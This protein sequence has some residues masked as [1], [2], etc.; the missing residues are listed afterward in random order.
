MTNL[1][2]FGSFEGIPL[3]LLKAYWEVVRPYDGWKCP[4]MT[5][6]PAEGFLEFST[7]VRFFT[8]TDLQVL[9]ELD[10]DGENCLFVYSVGFI[11]RQENERDLMRPLT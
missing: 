8:T 9:C 2:K 7:A 1:D 4:I 5:V 11:N 10:L 3:D 6:I